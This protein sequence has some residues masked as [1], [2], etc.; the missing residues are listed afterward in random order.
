[1]ALGLLKLIA[2]GTREAEPAGAADLVSQKE[3]ASMP[4]PEPATVDIFAPG[5]RA[6]LRE[7][8]ERAVSAVAG[9]FLT[10]LS[11]I[12]A[13]R[14]RPITSLLLG[15]A[16]GLL[17]ARGLTGLK[18]RQVK[19]FAEQAFAHRPDLETRFK[20]GKFDEVDLASADSFP[21]SDPPSYSPGVG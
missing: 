18:L 4:N 3:R 21:A 20:D 8:H 11:L 14:R 19:T 12:S 10:G 13:A 1:L 15:T 6:A 17:L 7:H 16:G 5:D 2:A 9:L